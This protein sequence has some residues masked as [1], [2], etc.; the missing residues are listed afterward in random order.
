MGTR[1]K[2]LAWKSTRITFDKSIFMF[3]KSSFDIYGLLSHCPII[4]TFNT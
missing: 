1:A 2:A 4:L 3:D